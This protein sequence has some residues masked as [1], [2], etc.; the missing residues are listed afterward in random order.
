MTPESEVILVQK[1]F[2]GQ[3]GLYSNEGGL[4]TKNKSVQ[5]Q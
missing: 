2:F 4:I 1:I 3:R 5:F